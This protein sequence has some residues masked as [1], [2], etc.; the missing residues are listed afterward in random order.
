MNHST[1]PD[2]LTVWMHANRAPN[3]QVDADSLAASLI[4]LWRNQE[5]LVRSLGAMLG[6]PQIAELAVELMLLPLRRQAALLS[7]APVPNPHQAGVLAG[8]LGAWLVEQVAVAQAAA[9]DVQRKDTSHRSLLEHW[10]E[11]FALRQVR[12][13]ATVEGQRCFANVCQAWAGL[14]AEVNP[15]QELRDTRLLRTGETKNPPLLVLANATCPLAAF[16]GI[17]G[18]LIYELAKRFDLSVVAW[19]DILKLH[20]CDE[21]S[22]SLV[23]LFAEYDSR[24]GGAVLDLTAGATRL[25]RTDNPVYTI[26]LDPSLQRFSGI[27]AAFTIDQLGLQH[28][29]LPAELLAVLCDVVYPDWAVSAWLADQDNLALETRRLWLDNLPSISGEL[30][31]DC[32]TSSTSVAD[33]KSTLLELEV[34]PTLLQLLN[35]QGATQLSE[36][37][38]LLST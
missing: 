29:V 17:E 13:L 16:I 9:V 19:G 1:L 5:E 31:A 8:A 15:S 30:L 27:F 18:G 7:L 2:P 35:G 20:S 24:G 12:Y 25:P 21:L 11:S 34:R 22:Q 37:V 33:Q 10:V 26:A 32:L 4:A 36:E 6:L 38:L 23:P 28:D 3:E 14:D